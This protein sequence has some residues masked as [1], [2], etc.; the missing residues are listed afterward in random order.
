MTSSPAPRT[1]DHNATLFDLNA[2]VVRQRVRAR[3]G[4]RS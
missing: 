4:L 2:A 1:T 3:D